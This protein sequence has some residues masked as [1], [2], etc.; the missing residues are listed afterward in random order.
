MRDLAE[1]ILTTFTP[2]LLKLSTVFVL[3]VSFFFGD[4]YHDAIVAVLM[5][6]IFDTVLGVA[7]VY[8]EGR[9]I[10]SRGF[11]RVIYKGFVYM[12][13]I[14]AGYFLD[15][16]LP[17]SVAQTTMIGFVAVTEFISILENMGRLDMETPK[18]LLNQLHDFQSAK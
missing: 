13:S 5:L 4:L 8:Y 11:A 16:T 18:K 14:S 15:S 9:A 17:I 12:V 2:T 7:A 10:T 6:M 1:I 3:T